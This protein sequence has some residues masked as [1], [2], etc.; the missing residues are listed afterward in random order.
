MTRLVALCTI[1]LLLNSTQAYFID[2]AH[3]Q[4]AQELINKFVI[5]F[6]QQFDAISAEGLDHIGNMKLAFD[7]WITKFKI[8]GFEKMSLNFDVD[9]DVL[10]INLPTVNL[11]II[12]EDSY[13]IPVKIE[14]LTASIIFDIDPTRFRCSG[15]EFDY[16]NVSLDVN[17]IVQYFSKMLLSL[18]MVKNAIKTAELPIR[19]VIVQTI[20][21]N[22]ER[23]YRLLS[24]L[25]AGHFDAD[26]LLAKLPEVHHTRIDHR[27][28]LINVR[29]IFGYESQREKEK[30]ADL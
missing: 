17:L 13:T 5:G 10:E 11:D 14:N 22:H 24:D 20:R 28:Y 9:H 27:E 6:T 7:Y 2:K 1:L 16:D 25:R 29:S 15:V 19:N 12:V 30:K 26:A 8:H 23:L 18:D 21:S 4:Q 3:R